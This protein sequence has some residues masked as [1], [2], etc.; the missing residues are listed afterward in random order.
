MAC[1]RAMFSLAPKGVLTTKN[2][3]LDC[4]S[5]WLDP[6]VLPP[7]PSS[8]PTDRSSNSSSISTAETDRNLRPLSSG[9]SLSAAATADS[10]GASL[11]AAATA[12]S[13]VAAEEDDMFVRLCRAQRRRNERKSRRETGKEPDCLIRRP[14]PRRG[15]PAEGEDR[16]REARSDPSECGGARS[17]PGAGP[18]GGASTKI[19][20]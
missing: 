1:S 15:Q 13:S 16:P 11:S 14:Q 20:L 12:D 9:A 8:D 10:S 7:K 4:R 2:T 19:S 18:A 6:V 5:P 17:P 3:F